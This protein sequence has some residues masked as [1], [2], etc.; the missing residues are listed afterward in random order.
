MLG[1]THVWWKSSLWRG[2]GG[3]GG[4]LLHCFAFLDEAA[5]K[6]KAKNPFAPPSLRVRTHDAELLPAEWFGLE[7]AEVV[8]WPG[9]HWGA[10]AQ[11]PLL[12]TAHLEEP[13]GFG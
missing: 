11:H 2:G 13:R 6:T 10:L 9:C 12:S 1:L 8:F 7:M 5:V 3:G 4:V